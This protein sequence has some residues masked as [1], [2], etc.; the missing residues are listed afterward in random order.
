MNIALIVAA[1]S[2]TRMGIDTPKQFVL[3]KDKPLLYYSVKM[4]ETYPELD[5][6]VI[7]TNKDNVGLVEEI[8]K[9]Y[10]FSKVKAIVVGG[11]TRQDSV[12]NGLTKIKEFA[13]DDDVVLIH[14][15]ARPLVNHRIIYDNI[16]ACLE[17]GAV[18]TVIQASDT[19]VKSS[20]GSGVDELPLRKE[21]YQA[22][23]PQTF[24]LGLILNAHEY[25]RTHQIPDVTDDVKLVISLGKEVHIVEGSK[26]N[27]KITT[28]EDLDL[29][30]ALL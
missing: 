7:V 28:P 2:G 12:Y 13:N 14:D 18:D 9:E 5:A 11:D 20:D 1:G 24:K 3:I 21:L 23:T 8:V 10:S 26:L 29:L 19:I 16:K 30:E 27:F 25:A 6:I 4:F 15:A 17:Y 22:Q